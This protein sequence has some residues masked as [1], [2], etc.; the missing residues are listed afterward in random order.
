MDDPA[1]D[2]LFEQ[3]EFLTDERNF[4]EF[5][6]TE[7]LID[8]SDNLKVATEKILAMSENLTQGQSTKKLIASTTRCDALRSS[9]SFSVSC[10]ERGA[11]NP[12]QCNF[13]TCWCVDEAGNQLPFTNTFRRGTKTCKQAQID[14]V[15][16]DLH[17]TNPNQ[18]KLRNLYEVVHKELNELL[19]GGYA[20]LRVHEDEEGV[21]KL[22][23]DLIDENKVNVAFAIEEMAREGNLLL[24][25]GMLRPDNTLS[26]FS[27]KLSFNLPEPQKATV[28]IAQNTFHTIVF[29]L[30]TSSAFIISIFVIYVMLKRGKSKDKIYNQNKS[31][32]GDK[33]I[34]Y[35]SPI[36]V[37]SANDIE[38]RRARSNIN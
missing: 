29:I 20:N 5:E 26:K 14:A 18:V 9:A 11:F 12:T 8:R 27:H 1:M 24:F 31:Y 13:D 17:L 35:N 3:I 19:D 34:D 7:Q 36:F 23:F 21:V 30:A 2:E 16:V 6:D 10:D 33:Y 22:R 4:L 37:L 32:G 28:G 25:H 38:S 15:E